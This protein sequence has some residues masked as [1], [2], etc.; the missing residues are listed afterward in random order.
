MALLACHSTDPFLPDHFHINKKVT[1][2]SASV[3]SIVIDQEWSS[4]PT[5]KM[6]DIYQVKD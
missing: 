4:L 3:P 6:S 2:Y 5:A 1:I